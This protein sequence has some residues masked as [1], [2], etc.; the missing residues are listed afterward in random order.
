MVI[1]INQS[2]LETIERT[3]EFLAGTSNVTFSIP[4]DESTLRAFVATVIRRFR[5][6]RQNRQLLGAETS[7]F[8]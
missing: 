1:D 7:I 5:Y 2:R 3:G 4:A 6:A 8:D